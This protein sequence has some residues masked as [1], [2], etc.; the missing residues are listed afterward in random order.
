[1]LK[2]IEAEEKYLDQYKEAYIEALN[3]IELGNIKK[4]DM[5]FLNPDETNVVQVFKDNRD[6]S[7]LPSHYVPSYD[8][9]AVDD[10]KFIGVI[11]IRIR[12][13]DNLVKFGGHIGYGINP[14]YWNMGYGK[15]LLK[16]ALDKYK[17]LIEEDK[18]LITCD[19]DNIGSYKIIE[20]NGGV[21]EN[22]I[23]NEASGEKF[24]TRRY[25]INK[26]LK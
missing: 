15:E 10:D 6:Q 21:L 25:W 26:K 7:K 24:L 8:F 3:Q 2:L 18:I 22:K 23:E 5:M 17:D 4:H 16:V 19:D 13:T 20:A 1:M 14:K 9:F 12:L 11:H